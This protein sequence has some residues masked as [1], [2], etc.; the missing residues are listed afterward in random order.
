M[1][2]A[3][4]VAARRTPI[5]KLN[6][7]LSSASAAQ[8]GTVAVS[9]ALDDAGIEPDC[10]SEV[11]MGQ[12]LTA[13]A[14]QNPARQTAIAAKIPVHVPA[15]TVNCVCGSGLKAIQLAAQ[16]IHSG[17]G[18]L[19]LAGGQESMSQA[20][21]AMGGLRRGQKLGDIAAKDTMVSDGLWDSFNDVH[22]GLTAEHLARL[23]TVTRD[24]QDAFALASQHKAAIAIANDRFAAELVAVPIAGREGITTVAADEQPNSKTTAEALAAL[25]P[26]FQPEGS[27]TAGNAS[28]LNDGA[29]AV[30]VAS[31]EAVAS[32][33]LTTRARIA[34]SA[35]VGVDPML[36]GLGPVF[37]SRKAL[38]IAGWHNNDLQLIEIN[39]AFAAVSVT[40][41]RKMD[42][43]PGI[44]NVNGGAIALGHP[45]GASGCR[46][47]VSLLHEMERRNVQRGLASLCI[48][49][50]MGIAICIERELS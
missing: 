49:G 6:G 21:H 42:W 24:E 44:I 15:T 7:S 10:I 45:L 8:L 14:G 30:V 38:Q 18:E 17:G 34:A 33:G 1:R 12:V 32:Y 13:G 40:I 28:S 37:A 26:A 35:L 36:M 9:A 50:G 29:A 46:V 22:M 27:V 43:D 41:Q 11:F 4:I 2:D 31:A 3:F 39:E 48:G 23:F 16:A 47:V 5:G 20:P 19:Y 25:R